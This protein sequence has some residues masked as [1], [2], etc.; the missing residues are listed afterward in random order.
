MAKDKSRFIS[1]LL[2]QPTPQ[3]NTATKSRWLLRLGVR[4]DFTFGRFVSRRVYQ[5]PHFTV[6]DPNFGL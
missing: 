5:R 6:G 4:T 2:I 1:W 3:Q